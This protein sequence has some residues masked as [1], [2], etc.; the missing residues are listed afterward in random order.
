MDIIFKLFNVI[1]KNSR[2]FLKYGTNCKSIFFFLK[3][4]KIFLIFFKKKLGVL[5]KH[6][7][8]RILLKHFRELKGIFE[9][10]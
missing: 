8:T 9:I 10:F 3:S 6:M 5:M 7:N 1:F 2:V 4:L